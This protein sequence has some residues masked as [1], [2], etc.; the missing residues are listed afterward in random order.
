MSYCIL[1]YVLV[2]PTGDQEIFK[3]ACRTDIVLPP[4][5]VLMAWEGGWEWAILMVSVTLG[6]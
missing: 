4:S 6:T 1:A 2:W 5:L 3:G